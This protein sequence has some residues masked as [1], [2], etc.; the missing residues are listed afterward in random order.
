MRKYGGRWL[1][2]LCAMLLCAAVLIHPGSRGAE[3]AAE[4]SVSLP[5]LMYHSLLKDPGAAGAYVLSPDAFAADIR[6]LQ[7]RGYTCVLPSDLVRFVDEGTPLPDKP[8]ML[9]LDD[10]CLNN[11]VY[12]LPILRALGAKA[13]ISPVGA[14]TDD[15]VRQA[16]PNPRYAYCTWD[17]LRTLAASGLV[18]LGNHSYALHQAGSR[19]GAT[20]R[21]GEA[22]SSYQEMMSADTLR[23]QSAMERELGARP[24]CYVYP[25]GFVDPDGEL[26]LRQ[27]GYRVTLSCREAVNCITADPESLFSLGRFNRPSGVS[28]ASFLDRIGAR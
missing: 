7:A 11:L 14:Y 13:V 8:V 3:T 9:T 23:M 21:R 2:P 28:S 16:D 1:I 18:E 24:V 25:Y 20:R 26:L 15:A 22:L 17:D 19:R 27:L 4:A 6:C 5:I 12:V 10:G